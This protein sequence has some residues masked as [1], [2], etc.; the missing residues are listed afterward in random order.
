MNRTTLFLDEGT[1][2]ELQLLAQRQKRP[3]A[4]LVREALGRYLDEAKR[5]KGLH[6]RFVA[7]GRS[8]HSDTARRSEE[9]PWGDLQPHPAD[10]RPQRRTRRRSYL[11]PLLLETGALYAL[12]DAD[13][14]WHIPVREFLKAERQAMLVPVTVIPE[15]AHLMRKQLGAVAETRFAESLAAGEIATEN[16][17]QRDIVR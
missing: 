1:N 3:V 17:T 15:A 5:G 2:R 8:G 6:L 14:D 11:V 4:A 10:P 12:A 7:A 16:L 9:L 13:D